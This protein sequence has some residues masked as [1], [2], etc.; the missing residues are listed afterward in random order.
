MFKKFFFI[1][2]AVFVITQA[3]YAARPLS[4]D[5][6]GTVE[7]EKFELE[8]GYDFI[9]NGGGNREQSMGA[10]I[11]AG[12][13]EGVDFGIA[14]PYQLEPENGLDQGEMGVKFSLLKERE[15][16][17]GAALTFGYNIGASE[18]ALCGIASKEIGLFT[19]H[20]NLGY[21]APGT[22][23]GKGTTTY[24]IGGEFSADENLTMVSEIVGEENGIMEGLLGGR[25]QVSEAIAF[26]LGAGFGFNEKSP[27]LKTTLGLTFGF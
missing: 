17:P 25:L 20:L 24:S 21:N 11:K 9:D 3:S 14:V 12:L 10:S 7:R 18:Y 26:D 19:V 27:D 15:N 8:V 22:V 16:A 6:A 23:D 4:T 13:T 5:D 2:G 1:F